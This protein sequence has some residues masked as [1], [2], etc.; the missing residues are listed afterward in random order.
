MTSIYD[1]GYLA[2]RPLGDDLYLVLHPITFGRLRLTV[3]TDD[4]MGEHW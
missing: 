1:Q 3:A 2:V 4:W